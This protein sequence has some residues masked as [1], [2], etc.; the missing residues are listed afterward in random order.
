MF[1]LTEG[2]YEQNQVEHFAER[3]KKGPVC[4]GITTALG[5]WDKMEFDATREYLKQNGGYYPSSRTKL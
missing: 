4:D 3:S 5:I 2:P 1:L